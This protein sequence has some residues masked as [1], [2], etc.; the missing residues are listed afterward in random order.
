MYKFGN[1]KTIPSFACYF[2]EEM[3]GGCVVEVDD[4]QPYHEVFTARAELCIMLGEEQKAHD[5]RSKLQ[6]N[7][8]PEEERVRLQDEII[9]AEELEK[10]LSSR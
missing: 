5:I 10:W 3:T 2:P 9:A 7:E 6:E 8:L 1:E 4:A